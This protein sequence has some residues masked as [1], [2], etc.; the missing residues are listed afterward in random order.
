MASG[1][2][3]AILR[4][5]PA[6]P[7]GPDGRMALADHLRELRARLI[8]S[9]LFLLVVFIAALFFFH[10]LFHLVE[11]PYTDAVSK[12][13]PDQKSVPT[14][15][16]VAGGFM[17]WMKVCGWAAILASAP[18][19]L[20]QIWAF[21]MP[22]LHRNERRWTRIFVVIAGPLFLLGVVLGYFTLPIGVRVLIGFT[23]AGL[24]N[25]VDFNEYLS[26]FTHTLLIFGIAFEIPVFVTLLNFAGVISGKA[27]A[28]ARPWIIVLTFVFAAVVTP[29][30]DPFTM[31]TLAVPMV[32]LFLL[33]E[34]VAHL[35]DKRRARTK[36][37]AGLSPDEP[38]PLNL[39]P[40]A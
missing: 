6:Q 2:L 3:V 14:A 34:V 30:T 19:W 12:L 7:V 11:R 4:G 5:R 27:L 38:S 18:F 35:H 8:L 40:R 21:V 31:V 9:V 25:L 36:P 26:F 1:G 39:D 37:N 29:S 17:L 24:T 13:R 16:G 28:S 23:P 20:Y 15:N 10:Q 22:G 33:S 32:L